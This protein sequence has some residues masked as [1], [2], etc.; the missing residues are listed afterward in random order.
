MTARWFVALILTA[1][2]VHTSAPSAFAQTPQDK[3]KRRILPLMQDIIAPVTESVVKVYADGKHV[4]LGT[5]VSADGFILTKGS[6]LR[7]ELQCA[8]K[9]GEKHVAVKHGYHRPTDL[10]LLKISVKDLKPLQFPTEDAADIGNWVAVPGN[11]SDPVAAG[12]ISVKAR[13]LIGFDETRIENANKGVLGIMMD[14]NENEVVIGSV[15]AE[16]GASKAGIRKG[17]VL[18]EV[19]SKKITSRENL[20]EVLDTYK[21]GDTVTVRVMRDDKELDFKVKLGTRAQDDQSAMQ[22]AM[23]GALSNR[24]TGF[25]KVIQHDTILDPK[26]CGGPLVDLDGRILGVNIARAGRVETWTLPAPLVRTVLKD[27]RDG[28]HVDGK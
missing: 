3:G 24:R 27:L 4:A 14:P 19:A 18:L 26:Q 9:D 20:F 25:P 10:A 28:K 11:T 17:D 1:G 12:V 16:S 22:N 8:T 5:I 15:A 2:V 7:G 23:G 21:P 6:D 13:K